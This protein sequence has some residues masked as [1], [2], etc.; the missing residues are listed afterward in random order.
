MRSFSAGGVFWRGSA[1][2]SHAGVHYA[3]DLLGRER[4]Q[5]LDDGIGERV[6][7]SRVPDIVR[8]NVRAEDGRLA[9]SVP[10]GRGNVEFVH[11]AT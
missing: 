6:A 7:D 1:F 10:I 2:R 5:R 4:C 9:V 8:G 3:T 11:A